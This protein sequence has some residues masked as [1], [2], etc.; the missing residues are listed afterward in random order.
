MAEAAPVEEVTQLDASAETPE[1]YKPEQT[2]IVPPPAEEAPLPP[3]IPEQETR[4]AEQLQQ[5]ETDSEFALLQDRCRQAASKQYGLLVDQI[6]V[7]STIETDDNKYSV[8]LNVGSSVVTCLVDPQGEVL[9]L[10]NNR[11][12]AEQANVD[13]NMYEVIRD[14]LPDDEALSMIV[15]SDETETLQTGQ[16]EGYRSTAY[17]LQARAN[18]TLEIIF[19]AN[20]TNAYF[21]VVRADM[22]YGEALFVGIQESL[23]RAVIRI[24]EDGIYLV[25]PYLALAAARQN[26]TASYTFRIS[27]TA[28]LTAPDQGKAD[29]KDFAP[30]GKS[31]PLMP[32]N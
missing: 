24:P 8:A 14:R 18:E 27:R 12:P 16:I 19:D 3:A 25:R 29:R 1:A 7:T 17:G 30:S 9:S 13:P 32:L 31:D 22:P 6:T 15:L 28:P 11:D 2:E 26:E 20:N 10:T 21:N 23:N 5:Q 4:E